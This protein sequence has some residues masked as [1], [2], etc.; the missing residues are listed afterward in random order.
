MRASEE[1]SLTR[2][3]RYLALVCILRQEHFVKQG[4]I[5]YNFHCFREAI[6]KVCYM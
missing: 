6:Q 3:R 1:E 2:T 5:E 4:I